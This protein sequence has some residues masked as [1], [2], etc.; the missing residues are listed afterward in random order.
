MGSPHAAQVNN[1]QDGYFRH[2]GA[3][4][5]GAVL[6]FGAVL[7]LGITG[8]SVEA[9]TIDVGEVSA[10]QGQVQVAVPLFLNLS[11]G[12]TFSAL[13]VD[14]LFDPSRVQCQSLALLPS[15]AALGK[16]AE[17]AIVEPGH[18]RIIVY[19]PNSQLLGSGNLGDILFQV[20]ASAPTG[21]ATLQLQQASGAT[22][23]GVELSLSKMDGEIFIDV[24]PDMTAPALTVSSPA[25]GASFT[26]GSTVSVAGTAID[27]KAVTLLNING[28]AVSVGSN[29]AFQTSLSLSGVAAGPF[30][31][32]VQAQDAAGNMSS[33]TRTIQVT[34]PTDTTCPIIVL[35]SPANQSTYT[36]GQP[37]PVSG[38]ITDNVA[39]PI[40]A[41]VNGQ[42][43]TL[44]AGGLFSINL[45]NLSV[46]TQNILVEAT[47]AA[48]N[49]ET[50]ERTVTVN[51]AAVPQIKTAIQTTA[52]SSGWTISGTERYAWSAPKWLE[53]QID[54]GA[55]GNWTC[56]LTGMNQKNTSAPGLPSGFNYLVTVTID[57]IGKGTLVLPG[58]TTG[59]KTGTLA[60]P[61]TSGLHTV[62]F[63]WTN[64]Y[65][66]PA[67]YDANLRVQQVAFVP[68]GAAV[69]ASTTP[70][71]T[72]INYT[73]AQ[74]SVTSSGWNVSGT[75]RYAFAA[76]QWLEYQIDF[77]AGGDWMV[78]LTA[79][80]H[81]YAPA[82]GLPS[83]YGYLIG[84]TLDGVSKGAFSVPGST[85]GYQT[86]GLKIS[87]PAGVHKIRLMWSNDAYSAG[88]YDAN[89]RVQGIA[90]TPQ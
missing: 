79:T 90:L 17:T 63:T 88:V 28:Q 71:P 7:A 3:A 56:A 35:T 14:L 83:G 26:I 48:G 58:S 36:Q 64:D 2:R 53:Y 49:L 32:G 77:G 13:S 27:N 42:S 10:I 46:G 21:D 73:A 30:S 19:G 29:G 85:T 82:P 67:L 75:E 65:W 72:S 40:V 22:P 89:I 11:S 34:A 52:V 47:D 41:K 61:V 51:A 15:I 23:N 6:V 60:I 81:K 16:Q 68:P 25:D 20:P 55:G 4:R 37:V 80:N 39:G 66:V 86:G 50:K 84:L 18:I 38:T 8:R 12:E 59:Y 78:N 9:A 87:V 57:G 33:I 43:V 62:R 1:L 69:P 54:F 45:T 44:G 5:Y 70:P 74:A 31:I 76:P 24:P